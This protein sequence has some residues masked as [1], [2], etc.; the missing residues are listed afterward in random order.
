[1][2][3]VLLV[4][5]YLF[6]LNNCYPCPA[7]VGLF[8]NI[9]PRIV[10]IAFKHFS[11]WFMNITLL[12]KWLCYDAGLKIPTCHDNFHNADGNEK[13][14][15]SWIN[16]N[17]E[18]AIITFSRLCPNNYILYNLFVFYMMC[19]RVLL[20]M[21][22]NS[23]KSHTSHRASVLSSYDFVIP[24]SVS[25]QESRRNDIWYFRFITERDVNNGFKMVL[26]NVAI[27]ISL[28]CVVETLSQQTVNVLN[29]NEGT[30]NAI[31]F[32]Y[33]IRILQG[34]RISRLWIWFYRIN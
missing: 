9:A 13:Y 5:D 34:E 17:T 25:V 2:N 29:L 18:I 14:A 28:H 15:L 30:C 8:I 22:E 19:K 23:I 10:D 7:K 26:V 27:L 21:I 3:Y 6:N 4:R 16:N 11:F 24:S 32:N 20:G 33:F 31:V 1:M 12:L